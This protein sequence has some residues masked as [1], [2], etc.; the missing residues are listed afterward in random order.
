MILL[1][2]LINNGTLEKSTEDTRYLVAFLA[3][4]N[5]QIP[6]LNLLVDKKLIDNHGM[7]IYA[8]STRNTNIIDFMIAQGANLEVCVPGVLHMLAQAGNF[9]A[10]EKEDKWLKEFVVDFPYLINQEDGD[11]T[12]PLI[13]AITFNNIKIQPLH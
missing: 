10:N 2:I 11:G 6:V 9:P 8:C 1:K 5:K 7:L 4:E 3:V 12:T 13:W